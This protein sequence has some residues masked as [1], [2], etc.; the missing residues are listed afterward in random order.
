MSTESR[1]R[2][3]K[4][5][6][7]PLIIALF[8]LALASVRAAQPVVMPHLDEINTTNSVFLDDPNFGRDPFFPLSTR[9]K[10][11]IVAPPTK[12]I[13]V[14]EIFG[15]VLESVPLKGI[16]GVPTKRLAL[17][18]NRTVGIGEEVQHRFNGRTYRVRCLEIHD[19]SV[20]LGV[21]GS[22]ETKEI[23]LRSGR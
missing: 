1:G 18:G 6:L 19:N 10:P 16:S 4:A 3:S 2:F 9:H 22:K 15:Q 21:D 20:L 14:E 23:R 11:V 12:S 13:P 7:S 17:L 5:T 8:L